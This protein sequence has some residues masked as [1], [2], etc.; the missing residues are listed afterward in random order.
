VI[1][2]EPIAVSADIEQRAIERRERERAAA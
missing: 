1:P 2:Y